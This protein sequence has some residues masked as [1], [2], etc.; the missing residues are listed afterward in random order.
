[1]NKEEEQDG[2]EEEKNRT[3]TLEVSLVLDKCVSSLFFTT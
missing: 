2:G 3:S 1:M